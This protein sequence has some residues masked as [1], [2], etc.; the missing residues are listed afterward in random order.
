M[1]LREND[2]H[3]MKIHRDG[4]IA[5]LSLGRSPGSAGAMEK[6]CGSVCHSRLSTAYLAVSLAWLAP[7][8]VINC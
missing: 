1:S 7:V 6:S 8:S 5:E 3:E 2:H 4:R